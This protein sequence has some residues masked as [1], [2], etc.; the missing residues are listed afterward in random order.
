MYQLLISRAHLVP[1]GELLEE[2]LLG[3]FSAMLMLQMWFEG[4]LAFQRGE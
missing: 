3:I 2:E 4:L 1:Q